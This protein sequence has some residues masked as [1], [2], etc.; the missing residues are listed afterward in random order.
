MTLGQRVAVMRDGRVLQ[1]DEPQRLY[2]EPRNLFVA[3]F[4]GSPAM[5][6]VEAT[7]D[8]GA[9]SFGNFRVPLARERRPEAR[10][11]RVVLGI[12]PE[13][14]EDAAFASREL[15]TLDVDVE[16]LEELGPDSHVIFPV[17]APT[18]TAEA[19]EAEDEAT[20][21]AGTSLFTARVDARTAAEAGKRHALVVDPA[22][23]HFFDPASGE[24]LVCGAPAAELEPI[25]A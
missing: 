6:L 15:P 19:L 8:D 20:L 10:T 13:G 23:F 22:R 3:A 12:R 2:Q 16:V 18:I 21:L 14:F 1:V 7:L 11:G 17:D 4:I 9:V 5:N 24:S 25:G